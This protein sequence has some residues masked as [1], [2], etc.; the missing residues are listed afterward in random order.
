MDSKRRK[1]KTEAN[2]GVLKFLKNIILPCKKNN[3]WLPFSFDFSKS[4][5]GFVS[6]SNETSWKYFDIQYSKGSIF[7]C[8]AAH[9]DNIK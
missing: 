4:K 6:C 9:S 5:K 2:G 1:K 3:T 8:Q 7:T